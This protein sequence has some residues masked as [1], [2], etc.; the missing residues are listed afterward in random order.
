ML[1]KLLENF[2]KKFSKET[3]DSYFETESLISNMIAILLNT[4]SKWQRFFLGCDLNRSDSADSHNTIWGYIRT[5]QIS[6]DYVD[7]K[8]GTYFDCSFVES[9]KQ[10]IV[11]SYFQH[12]N[13]LSQNNFR[14]RR[15]M[16]SLRRTAW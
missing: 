16:P 8:F 1:P 13:H 7:I 2:N 15:V 11:C 5:N 14:G 4:F 10:Y 9:Y 12:S 3:L 6:V